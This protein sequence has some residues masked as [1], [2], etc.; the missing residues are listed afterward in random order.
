[1]KITEEQ[2]DMLQDLGIQV[3]SHD[4][5]IRQLGNIAKS[6]ARKWDKFDFETKNKIQKEFLGV[7]LTTRQEDTNFLL[8]NSIKLTEELIDAMRVNA[9][10]GQD[11]TMLDASEVLYDS[12]YKAIKTNKYLDTSCTMDIE[13][14]S[15]IIRYCKDHNLGFV[16]MEESE[17][18]R[19]SKKFEFENIFSLGKVE[20]AVNKDIDGVI[21]DMSVPYSNFDDIPVEIK[22]GLVDALK[23][24]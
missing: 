5:G 4:G 1:M 24:I 23:G 15:T 18:E 8:A 11:I 2:I 19:L 21:V 14:N 7:D 16:V 22:T 12:L 17:A 6:L 10:L 20:E 9:E 3:R 13:P